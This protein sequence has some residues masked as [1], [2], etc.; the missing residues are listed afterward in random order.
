MSSE[1]I[2]IHERKPPIR[3]EQWLVENKIRIDVTPGCGGWSVRLSHLP[4]DFAARIPLSFWLA[5]MSTPTKQDILRDLVGQINVARAVTQE[6][7][8]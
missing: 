5:G 2:T 8:L 3:I 6:F 4:K 1:I 7:V